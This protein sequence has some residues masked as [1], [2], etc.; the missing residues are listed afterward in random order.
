[1]TRVL[2]DDE[3]NGADGRFSMKIEVL[4][5][6]LFEQSIQIRRRESWADLRTKV[7]LHRINLG[8]CSVDFLLLVHYDQSWID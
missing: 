7:P 5:A 8:R 1:M 4:E 3:H 2:Q 6:N